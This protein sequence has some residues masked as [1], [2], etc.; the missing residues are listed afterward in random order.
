M[1]KLRVSHSFVRNAL[2]RA[3]V[4]LSATASLGLVACLGRVSDGS[5]VPPPQG[6]EGGTPE[7][8]VSADVGGPEA[9]VGTDGADNADASTVSDAQTVVCDGVIPM[10]RC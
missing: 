4:T 3:T 5:P 10:G 1:P 6:T 9:T 2:L 8:P 7:V